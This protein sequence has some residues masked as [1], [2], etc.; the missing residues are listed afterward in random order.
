MRIST[1]RGDSGYTSLLKGGR[2][3]KHHLIIEAGGTL[4]EANSLLAVARASSQH[5]RIKRIILQVQ[6]HLFIIGAEFSVSKD[7]GKAPKKM[8][9]E[10]DIKWLERLVDEFEEALALPPGFVAFGQ[11]EGSSHLDVARTSIRKVERLAAKMKSEDM[12]ANPNVLRY[13]N[14]LSDLIFLLACFEEK[15]E[16]EKQKIN[17]S[18]FSSLLADPFSR[19][20]AIVSASIIFMLTVAIVLILIFH[21]PALEESFNYMQNH[22]KQ[23]EST[24]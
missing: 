1:K 8:I 13:L 18:L 21:R 17:Q 15:D 12:I 23:M 6:K 10:T 7:K 24:H 14:R 5:R 16:A 22:M 2:V 3:P 20:W 4:D 11:N 19:K 9:G